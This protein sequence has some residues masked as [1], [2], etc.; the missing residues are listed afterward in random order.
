MIKEFKNNE[1]RK[2][3]I[4]Y[5]SMFEQIKK[6]HATDPALAGELAISAIELILT[7]EYSSDNMMIDM[8]LIPAKVVNDGNVDKFND[9]MERDRA[10]QIESLKLEQISTL[11]GQGYT[12]G[13]IGKLIGVSQQT[14]SKRVQLIKKDYPELMAT[15]QPKKVVESCELQPKL[16][17]ESSKKVVTPVQEW[18]NNF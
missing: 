9:K 8:A 7:D 5:R 6:M 13:Q 2:S 10:R 17:V 4:V 1:P 12:Q 15:S 3:G 18:Y 14:V 11:L 16:V